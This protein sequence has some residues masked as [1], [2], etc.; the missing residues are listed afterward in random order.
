MLF[1]YC[2]LGVFYW[3]YYNP[4]SEYTEPEDLE[5]MRKELKNVTGLKKYIYIQCIN[6]TIVKRVID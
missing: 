4:Y 5:P 2:N 1:I 3:C 6:E